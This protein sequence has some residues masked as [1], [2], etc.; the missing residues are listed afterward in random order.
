[1][2]KRQKI[3]HDTQ[4]VESAGGHEKPVFKSGYVLDE[5]QKAAVSSN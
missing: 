1:M 3:V 4:E 2:A 5:K